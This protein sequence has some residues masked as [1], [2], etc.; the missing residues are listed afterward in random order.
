MLE[1]RPDPHHDPRIAAALA[2]G[3]EE[4]GGVAETALVVDADVGGELRDHLVAQAQAELDVRE[5]G[6]DPEGWDVLGR[7]VGLGAGLQDQ[8]L[9][10]APVERPFEAGGEV[11]AVGE[12]ER[13][14]DLE[15]VGGEALNADGGVGARTRLEVLP[16]A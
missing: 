9:G 13:A 1:P 15:E 2:G 14:L 4:A 16:H 5:S 8:L 11:A 7:E 3:A 12:E 10:E 6:A